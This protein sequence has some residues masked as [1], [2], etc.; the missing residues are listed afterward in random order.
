MKVSDADALLLAM[1]V[2][3]GQSGVAVVPQEYGMAVTMVEANAEV[4][5]AFVSEK[6]LAR[7]AKRLQRFA[8]GL[9][10]GL[11]DLDPLSLLDAEAKLESEAEEVAA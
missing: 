10:V 8:C 7:T 3:L 5:E 11:H 1:D 4:T 6:E 9:A 2:R